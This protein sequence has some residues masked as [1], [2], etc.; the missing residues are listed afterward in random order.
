[1]VFYSMPIPNFSKESIIFEYNN[2]W[3]LIKEHYGG[4]SYYEYEYKE[5]KI[6]VRPISDEGIIEFEYIYHTEYDSSDNL[7]YCKISRSDSKY[8][9]EYFYEYNSN[10]N[11]VKEIIKEYSI[12]GSTDTDEKFYYYNS[13]DQ[14]E[15]IIIKYKT[16]QKKILIAYSNDLITKVYLG[17][18]GENFP[19]ETIYITYNNENL[20]REF[21]SSLN[22]YRTYIYYKVLNKTVPIPERSINENFFIKISSSRYLVE[23]FFI[24]K[25]ELDIPLFNAFVK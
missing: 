16:R 10:K 14:I 21:W 9:V 11:L 15:E 2:S 20:P 13:K 24:D 22:N 12:D 3:E 19:E 5:H 4:D 23:D 6:T 25:N 7:I 18:N 17:W 1:M 8:Y